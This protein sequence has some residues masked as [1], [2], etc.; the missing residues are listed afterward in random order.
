MRKLTVMNSKVT[1]EHI[2]PHLKARM[3]QRGVTIEEIEQTLND[4]WEARDA[5]RGTK[6]KVLV[7]PYAAEW[8]GCFYSEKEITVYYKLL[9]EEVI[10]LT[11]IARY[12]DDFPHR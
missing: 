7:V 11:G 1:K 9:D 5:K 3:S 8:E 10:L 6:G 4:G 12:G 2:H